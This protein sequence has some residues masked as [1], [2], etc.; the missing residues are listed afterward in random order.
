MRQRLHG[1]VPLPARPAPRL[2]SDEEGA[3][4]RARLNGKDASVASPRQ[5]KEA[6]SLLALD[7]EPSD[8]IHG[9]PNC[10]FCPQHNAQLRCEGRGKHRCE[11]GKEL[12]DMAA[13][14][15]HVLRAACY[16][17]HAL[18]ADASLKLARAGWDSGD[19]RFFKKAAEILT[20]FA[21]KYPKYP[22]SDATATSYY[23][24]IGSG[25]LQESWWY[26]PL[27]RAYDLV[28]AAGVWSD[29]EVAFVE[30]NLILEGVVLLR[31]HR[32]AANQ[33]AEY[34]RGVG[35]G[36]LAIGSAALA[37]E[38]LSGEYGM[39]AQWGFDFDADGWTV[40]RDDGYQRAAIFPFL[41]FA[42]ALS[43][44][45]VPVFDARLKRLLDAPILRSSNL[46]AGPG[47]VYTEAWQRYHDPLYQRS[48][49]AARHEPLPE[50]P[51]GFPN[52]VQAAGGFTVL[53]S[54]RN[55]ADLITAA[56]NWGEPVFR[57]GRTLLSPT[58]CWRGHE[59]N[60]QVM[61]IAYGSR[62]SP[63]SYTA[64]AGNTLA[65]DGQLQSMA[66]T[67][68]RA[69]LGGPYPAGRWT[70]PA[71]RSQY[72]GVEWS[73]SLAI[74][75]DSVVVLDQIASARP[76][77]MDRFT[78]LPVD[79]TQARTAEGAEP[80]WTADEAFCG[81]S[82][83][84]RF[85]TS[86]ERAAGVG[87]ERI[88]FPLNP[89]RTRLALLHFRGPDNRRT[90]R[91]R[92]PIKWNVRETQAWVLQLASA[93]QAWFAEALSGVDTADGATPDAVRLERVEVRCEDRVLA[94]E[95]AL[96]VRVC[97]AAGEFLVLTSELEGTHRVDGHDM[98]GPLAVLRV[99]P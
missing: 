81:V 1:A 48:M 91:L 60:T 13:M 8:I 77:R 90:Y 20:A 68:Q 52:S 73:R 26:A 46:V 64:T 38:A 59:L 99:K 10:Y 45:G 94:P 36:A 66:R 47:D 42:R 62:F 32:S 75:G 25:N 16:A 55:D 9:Q 27:P 70:A 19:R 76:V 93:K 58:V 41:D 12:V 39:R 31:A 3:A 23:G 79:A 97:N 83:E 84:Y 86:V 87:P 65:I 17:E 14:P 51:E 15:D 30:R 53:R 40:E 33:Q 80:K 57:G 44:A 22:I 96:A 7:P 82:K 21:R 2:L 50:L 5:L 88:S 67:E 56:I 35:V 71:T 98:N 61:R 78:Y 49:A 29:A 11:K 28:R 63:F 95:Q 24:R 74:C 37:A 89:K 69:L 85:F 72:P 6:E 43:A 92:A 34:N 18:L 4:G 54:G